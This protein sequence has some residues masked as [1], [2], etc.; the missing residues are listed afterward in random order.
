MTL[1]VLLALVFAF[2]S[3]ALQKRLQGAFARRPGA[4]WLIPVLLTALFAAA[5]A[6][7]GAASLMLIAAM[8]AYTAAP[9]LCVLLAG[10][11]PADKPRT[12]DFAAI[13]LLWLPLEFAAGAALVPKPAQG[14]LHS[15]A[16]GVAILLGLTLF[17]CF[18]GFGGMK[19]NLPRRHA[20][21]V[22]PLAGFAILAPILIAV[23]IP[24]GFI[25]PPHLPTAAAGRMAAG[26][27]IIFAGTALPEEILFRALIQ[28]LIMQ[29]W[30]ANAR[31]LLAAS[32]IFGAA[33]LDNGP[34]PLPNWRYMILATIA[35]VAYGKVFQKATSVV[36]S[37]LLHT[38][39]DWTK[40]FI[41]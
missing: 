31:T 25:P 40:H 36:S 20:D 33:H 10:A 3:R 41:F 4:V 27:G 30:G 1:A 26:F 22:L 15:V 11:G 19:Y 23:G 32:L 16:Y 17:L 2:F 29:R 39:V 38:M 7:A 14:F 28:N 24:I 37:A 9:T 6:S 13:L 21:L 8:L 5:A 34:Q 12:L 35:G 18:R